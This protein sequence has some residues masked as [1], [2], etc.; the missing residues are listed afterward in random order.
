MPRC[1]D[2]AGAAERATWADGGERPDN[3]GKVECEDPVL[4][5]DYAPEL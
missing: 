4:L 2:G 1:H 3:T 5:D